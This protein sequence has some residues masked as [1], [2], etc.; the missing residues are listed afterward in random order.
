MSLSQD[1]QLA[2]K[3]LKGKGISGPFSDLD[4]IKKIC[5]EINRLRIGKGIE[6]KITIE[7]LQTF[8]NN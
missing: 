2:I 5:R 1:V 8:L 7:S 4:Y 3:A 6:K